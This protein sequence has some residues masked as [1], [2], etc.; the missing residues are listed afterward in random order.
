MRP[1]R[2]NSCRWRVAE[3]SGRKYLS[4]TPPSLSPFLSLSLPLSLSFSLFLS[5]SQKLRLLLLEHVDVELKYR[6]LLHILYHYLACRANTTEQI[7]LIDR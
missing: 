1:Y 7:F 5:I 6:I 4:H 2:Y 3:F